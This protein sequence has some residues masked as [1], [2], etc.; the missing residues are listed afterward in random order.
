MVLGQYL[1]E[2]IRAQ[3]ERK[4]EL[5][6]GKQRTTYIFIEAV[7]KVILEVTESAVKNFRLVAT[8]Q[9]LRKTAYKFMHIPTYNFRLG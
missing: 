3:K 9:N 2:K 6:A 1:H 8:M 5:I 4:N 7:L